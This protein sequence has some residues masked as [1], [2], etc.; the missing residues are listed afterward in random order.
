MHAVVVGV[1]LLEKS[2]PPKNRMI[3]TPIPKVESVQP[4][5]H[6]T[7][8]D[9]RSDASMRM[10]ATIAQGESAQTIASGRI[11]RKR[12]LM[13]RACHIGRR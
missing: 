2:Y 8:F 10:T 5:S 9:G 12:L 6:A 3:R 1:P 7:E 4:A 13:R 11:S